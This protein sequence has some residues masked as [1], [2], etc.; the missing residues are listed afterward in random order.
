M[1]RSKGGKFTECAKHDFGFIHVSRQTA[2]VPTTK[3]GFQWTGS[4]VKGLVG[5]GASMQFSNY[6]RKLGA[7]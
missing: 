4:A 6:N 3:A 5:L 2:Q 7:P 1:I